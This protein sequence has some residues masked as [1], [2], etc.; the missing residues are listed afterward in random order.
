MKEL[1][2]ILARLRS[3][4]A[5]PAALA[6]LARARG[7]S[8]RRPGARLLL[9]ADGARTGAISGGCLED[10]VLLRAKA[11]AAGGAAQAVTYDTTA[12]N[13]LVWGV[14]LGCHGVVDVVVEKITD[15]SAG[16]AECVGAAWARREDAAVAVAFHADDA[17]KLGT[18]AALAGDGK[19]FWG[20]TA[21]RAG[22]EQAL[23]RGAS[24]HA[25]VGGAEFFFELVARPVP[26]VI[27]GAGDDARPLCRMAAELGF[28][29]SVGDARPAHAT[30]ERFPEA[31][32]VL[33]DG[34][35]MLAGRVAL[36]ERT[37]A[38]VM[39]HH[40]VHDV[41]LLRAL[42]P[43]PLA[44]LGLLGPRQ[45]AEKILADLAADGLAV[46]P[47][48]RARLRAPV[49]LDVGATTPETVALAV[50][51]EIQAV[52]AGRDGRPLRERRGSIHE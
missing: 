35:E 39:T 5:F 3:P 33:A 26:L 40:Y 49:G 16:W 19:N 24:H 21:L 23:A 8:Y 22:L 31:D 32:T 30:R 44:Y 38:V 46:T 1:R 28:A 15:R 47:E 29:V 48:M 20:D 34:P 13:D 50:L 18:R 45:R 37:V 17:A 2:S 43:R 42:L 6:T 25:A 12:E 41:P 7:S 4:A 14:G 11:V 36:D 9:T 10:D 51:A 27:F 52:L